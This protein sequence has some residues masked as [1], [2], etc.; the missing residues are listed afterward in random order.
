MCDRRRPVSKCEVY[1]TTTDE[2]CHLTD[3]PR[4][5]VNFGLAGVGAKVYVVGGMDPLT[6]ET[7]ATV[8]VY[9]LDTDTWDTDFP[10]LRHPRK[11]CAV[12]YDG[13]NLYAVAGASDDLEPLSTCERFDV[14][15]RQWQVVDNCPRAFAASSAAVVA[16]RPV[17]LMANYR[18]FGHSTTWS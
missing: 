17:R 15:T 10:S 2:Y 11:S 1:D 16:N 12:F 6:F 5:M 4:M 18:E 7:K 14:M 13:M 8:M 3:L 9:D